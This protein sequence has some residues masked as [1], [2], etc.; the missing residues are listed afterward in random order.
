MYCV[1]IVF[2]MIIQTLLC[3]RRTYH[4]TTTIADENLSDMTQAHKFT[5]KVVL[6][7]YLC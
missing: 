4:L 5:H 2:C 3:W 1:F 7:L 6:N